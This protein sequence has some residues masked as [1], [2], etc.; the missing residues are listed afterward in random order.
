M[1]IIA[2]MARV[3]SPIF[4]G[5]GAELERLSDALAL[6]TD[7]RPAT[8]LVG[9]DAGIGKTRLVSELV[10]E[11]RHEDVCIL[12]GHCTA[13]GSRDVPLGPFLD[14]VRDLRRCLGA[15]HFD[16]LAGGRLADLRHLLP[17]LGDPAD[18]GSVTLSPARVQWSTA[19]LLR[20]A[21][22]T[23]PVLLVLEDVHWA[24]RSS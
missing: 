13:A 3:S 23:R 2:T 16:R 15:S 14:A 24:D 4:V 11:L 20:D 10:D 9:G 18:G 22:S 5:R 19:G 8:S 12:Q 21:A 17:E 7:Q 6:A 1:G